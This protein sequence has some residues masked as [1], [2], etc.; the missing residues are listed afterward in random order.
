MRILVTGAT[1]FIGSH[2]AR[3]L[4]ERG[5]TVRIL[6][7]AAS[8]IELLEGLPVEQA[9]G[10]IL[11][12]PSLS[13]A[14]AGIEAVV[15]CAA[16]MGSRGRVA[17]R[18][19]SHIDGTRN[20]L[21]AATAAG[22]R[23]FIYTSSVAALGIPD[24]PPAQT[25]EGIQPLD[26]THEWRGDPSGWAYGHA[27]HQAE[28]M[29]RLAAQQGMEAVILNPAL[30]IGPGDRNL[31]SNAFIWHMLRGRVPPLLPGGLNV[32]D[33]QDV[34]DGYL[35]AFDRGRPGERYLLCGENLPL[36]DLITTTAAVVGRRPPRLRLSLRTARTVGA[37]A[38]G[39]AQMVRAPITLDLLR[40]AGVYFY[41]DGSKARRE[42]GLGSPRTFAPAAT[43]SA[44]W[45][46]RRMPSAHP[47]R[48]L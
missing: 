47:A 18:L 41:Y 33:I 11:D 27:K 15:H 36:G 29:V 46:R 19:D 30:V 43:A 12:L 21:A 22:V 5:D 35:A 14:C 10:D 40:V 28:Q 44:E 24:H 2:V 7:R 3:A 1:G 17:A 26:E 9:I 37:L 32:V 4:V 38:A 42:L 45:Y 6:R 8:S 48:P 23:R 34:T 25:D 13:A 20:M 16:Q 39:L 31:V